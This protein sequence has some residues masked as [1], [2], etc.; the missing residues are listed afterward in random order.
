MRDAKRKVRNAKCIVKSAICIEQL[1]ILIALCGVA[2]QTGGCGRKSETIASTSSA[3]TR[4]TAAPAD[5]RALRPVALPDPSGTAA[6][7]Q[8]QLR[9][10]ESLLTAR[11]QT[12]GAT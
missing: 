6:S 10:R 2:V 8:K 5:R 12:A 1:A 4:S 3:Q 11:M 9:E 7:V